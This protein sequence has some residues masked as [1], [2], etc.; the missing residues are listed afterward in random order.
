MLILSLEISVCIV[1]I[2]VRV[3]TYVKNKGVGSFEGKSRYS[4]QFYIVRIHE[5]TFNSYYED[6]K[7]LI[8]LFFPSS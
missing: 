1:L 7:N 2:I 8:F 4:D 3:G 6:C 5:V